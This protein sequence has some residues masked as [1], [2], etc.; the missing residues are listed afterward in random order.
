MLRRSTRSFSKSCASFISTSN[1]SLGN[2][3]SSASQPTPSPQP[4]PH[5]RAQSPENELKKDELRLLETAYRK[6]NHIS[7]RLLEATY[8]SSNIP[9][10]ESAKELSSFLR[11]HKQNAHFASFTN[12]NHLPINFGLN[13]N[14]PLK[15]ES[16]AEQLRKVAESFRAVP[17]KYSFAYGLKVFQQKDNNG[18]ANQTDVIMATT[19][20]SH[21][22]LLNLYRHPDHYSFLGSFGS[23]LVTRV[24]NAGPGVYFNPYVKIGD[25]TVKYGVVSVEKCLSDLLNWDSLY[26]AGRLQKPVRILKDDARIRFAVQENLRNAVAVALLL[27]RDSKMDL[28]RLFETIAGLSYHGDIRTMIGGENPKKVHNIVAAQGDEFKSLYSP[29][30]NIFVEDN[31]IVFDLENTISIN[32][33]PEYRAYLVDNLPFNLKSNLFK[34]HIST[35]TISVGVDEETQS[36]L[37]GKARPVLYDIFL[38]SGLGK[39]SEKV[40]EEEKTYKP[41]EF[42]LD[43]VNAPNF[44]SMVSKTLRGIVFYPSMVQAVKGVFTAGF[45]K[46]WNYAAEKRRKY[47][48]GA[49]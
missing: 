11:R 48:E 24:Q 7:Q 23:E 33:S 15:S 1:A 19:Y 2:S 47:N 37:S 32:D 6:Y 4:I 49:K 3:P 45:G 21:F 20:P 39:A 26:L 17:I 34:N 41:S 22:H 31:F 5:N 18:K 27:S 8:I 43:L 28:S 40:I 42:V 13:Q 9:P 29:L 16:T 46:S 25:S 12:F 38:G 44:D 10:V 14:I 35:N 30:L 36:V